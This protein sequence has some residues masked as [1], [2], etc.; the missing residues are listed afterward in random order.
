[1]FVEQQAARKRLRLIPGKKT[2]EAIVN[3]KDDGSKQLQRL[4]ETRFMARN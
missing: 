2:M 3:K 4:D 1:M